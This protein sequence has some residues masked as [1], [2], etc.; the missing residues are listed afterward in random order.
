MDPKNPNL[1]NL[2]KTRHTRVTFDNIVTLRRTISRHDMTPQERFATWY[3]A[4]EYTII[5]HSCLKQISKLERGEKLKNKKYCTLGLEGHTESGKRE[6]HYDRFLAIDTVLEIQDRDQHHLLPE[7]KAEQMALAYRKA[8]A[9]AV[10]RAALAAITANK[11]STKTHVLVPPPGSSTSTTIRIL[12][13]PHDD[14]TA[15]STSAGKD[16]DTYSVPCA[17]PMSS[18]QNKKVNCIAMA[19]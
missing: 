16:T 3:S 4:D 10:C 11:S 7:V 14:R 9:K 18:T 2:N 15:H 1:V 6:K 8:S 17:S 13:D 19:A 12:V 5:R